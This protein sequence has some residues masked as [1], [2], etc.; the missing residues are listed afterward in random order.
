MRIPED[1]AIGSEVF[2]VAAYPR[3]QLNMQSLDGVS[4]SRMMGKRVNMLVNNA[5]SQTKGYMPYFSV[6]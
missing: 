3:Q 1:A 4:G 2:T 5:Q 6:A